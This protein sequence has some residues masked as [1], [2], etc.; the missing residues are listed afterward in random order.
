MMVILE[1]LAKLTDS[2]VKGDKLVEI[3][4]VAPLQSAKKGE[5]SFVSNPKYVTSLET[6]SA[7]AVILGKCTY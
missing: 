4:A 2:T 1:T 7:S 5:I 3:D 6:T